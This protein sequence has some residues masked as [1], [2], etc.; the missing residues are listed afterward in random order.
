MSRE[1]L[2]QALNALLISAPLGH[3]MEDYEYRHKVIKDIE[4][5]LAK[6]NQTKGIKHMNVESAINL[7]GM[8]F[9]IG[10]TSQEIMFKKGEQ[11]KNEMANTIEVI[12]G[13]QDM[14][15]AHARRKEM[16]DKLD[17]WIDGVEE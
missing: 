1:L 6:S 3:A 15:I 7:T 14:T 10:T 2:Q 5:E 8:V 12:V 11:F 13:G 4:A 16:H 17:A 9:T